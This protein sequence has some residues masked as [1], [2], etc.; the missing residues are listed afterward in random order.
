MKTTLTV[1]EVAGPR[2]VAVVPVR[3]HAVPVVSAT[4]EYA[5]GAAVR[6]N[7]TSVDDVFVRV[8]VCGG[9]AVVPLST[10]L[11]D[12]GDTPGT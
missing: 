5:E 11:S 7:D 10:K 3:V 9:P 12:E 8:T 6:V 4:T 2:M 1:Q